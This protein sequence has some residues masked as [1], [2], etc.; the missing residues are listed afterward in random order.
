[1]F[2]CRMNHDQPQH[3]GPRFRLCRKPKAHGCRIDEVRATGT[4][5]YVIDFGMCKSPFPCIPR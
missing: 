3:P 2:S 4:A 5:C 1:M